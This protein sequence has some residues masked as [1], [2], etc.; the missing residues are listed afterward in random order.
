MSQTKKKVA[1]LF[2]FFKNVES[3]KEDDN[4][5]PEWMEKSISEG[6]HSRCRFV[7]PIEEEEEED[8]VA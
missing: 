4:L 8:D 5:E 7:E 3:K 6:Q 2:K 1:G